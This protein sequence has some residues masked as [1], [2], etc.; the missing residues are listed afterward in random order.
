MWSAGYA[1]VG[2][3]L[4]VGCAIET[5]GLA[6]RRPRDA[7]LDA[8]PAREAGAV[9]DG[10]SDAGYVTDGALDAPTDVDAAGTIQTTSFRNNVDGYRGTVD[11]SIDESRPGSTPPDENYFH[12]SSRST[13]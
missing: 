13:G 1:V 3:S 7:G 9:A 2:L 8:S 4:L 5:G 10:A 6:D 12:W 11:T